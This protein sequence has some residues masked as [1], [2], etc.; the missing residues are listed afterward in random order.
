[1]TLQRRN[2]S[3]L[4]DDDQGGGQG[5]SRP[6]D[7]EDERT[8]YCQACLGALFDSPRGW[9]SPFTCRNVQHE[10]PKVYR[11]GR[12]E[13]VASL[14]NELGN[15]S[16]RIDIAKPSNSLKR[17]KIQEAFDDIVRV[18]SRICL[19]QSNIPEKCAKLVRDFSAISFEVLVSLG[20]CSSHV[21]S[22]SETFQTSPPPRLFLSHLSFRS[23]SRLHLFPLSP[24][25][26]SPPPLR[27]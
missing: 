1:M 2:R 23:T 4:T 8:R 17:S 26:A 27:L 5:R 22:S 6:Q 10:V 21:C 3:P 7:K 24:Q 18:L 13:S 14:A 19:V 11:F 12:S 15:A 9:R 20:H 25:V 16:V